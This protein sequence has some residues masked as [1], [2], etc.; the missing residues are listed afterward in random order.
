MNFP[1]VDAF[2]LGEGGAST[3]LSTRRVDPQYPQGLFVSLRLAR[4]P[5]PAC[6]PQKT[7]LEAL[8]EVPDPRADNKRHPLPAILA[9]SVGA[10]LCG[11]TT[12]LAI[13]ERGRNRPAFAPALGFRHRLTPYVATLSNVFRTLNARALERALA[14]YF[15]VLAPA[16]GASL[17]G[18]Q[19]FAVDGK[20]L[21]GTFS[22]DGAAGVTFVAAYLHPERR[23]LDQER[24][25]TDGELGAVR[26]SRCPSKGVC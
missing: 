20:A 18:F 6:T 2:A 16:E 9:L 19:P 21:H 22:D 23:V 24:V 17:G 7:L 13:A 26:C 12:L 11:A 25:E 15:G 10:V 5:V 4:A 14:R 3:G 8:A 1:S